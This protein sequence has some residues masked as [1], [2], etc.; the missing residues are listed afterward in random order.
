MPA[1]TVCSHPDREAIDQALAGGSDNATVATAHGL[2]K[3][4]VR[5]HRH[6]HLSAALKAVATRR[7]RAGARK[8][9]DRLEEL[10]VRATALLDTA[11]TE[12]NMTMTLGAVKELRGLVKDLARLTGEYDDKPTVNVLN[13]ATSPEWVQLRGAILAALEPF[14]DAAAAVARAV[15]GQTSGRVIEA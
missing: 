14:P 4:A 8:A 6:N 10:H 1:C 9:V 2:K 3:D 12:G 13:V 15:A 11:E 5:R 7:E